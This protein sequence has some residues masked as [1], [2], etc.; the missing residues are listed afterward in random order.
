[1]RALKRSKIRGTANTTVGACVAKS[2]ASCA[3]PR[4]NTTSAP[5]DSGR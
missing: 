4:A 2:S 5:S 1:M 3:I